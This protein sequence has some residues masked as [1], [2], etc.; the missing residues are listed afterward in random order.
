MLG[1]DIALIFAMTATNKHRELKMKKQINKRMVDP[2]MLLGDFITIMDGNGSEVGVVPRSIAQ[3]M[4]RSGNYY[5]ETTT[6]IVAFNRDDV[7]II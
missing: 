7:A 6:D 5:I 4:V 2:S 1:T 3:S